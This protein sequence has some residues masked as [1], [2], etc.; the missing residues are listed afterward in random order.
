[1]KMI[2]DIINKTKIPDEELQNFTDIF[3]EKLEDFMKL[4]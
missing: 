2:I 3:N 1:M 4:E